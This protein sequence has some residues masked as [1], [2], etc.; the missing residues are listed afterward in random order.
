MLREVRTV[1]QWLRRVLGI[2]I[3]ALGTIWLGG[4]ATWHAGVLLSRSRQIFGQTLRCPRGH[5]LP[6]FGV[7]RCRV[8]G[9]TH[10]GDLL[11]AC[12]VCGASPHWLTCPR[13]HLAVRSPWR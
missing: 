5:R 4:R 9:A 13:C 12:P 1:G 6:S 8:C 2:F 7:Y 10:E 3:W 11:G